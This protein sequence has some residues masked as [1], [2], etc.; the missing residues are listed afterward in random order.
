M[1]RIVFKNIE[2]FYAC[3]EKQMDSS[4]ASNLDDQ[5]VDQV[6]DDAIGR[7]NT[8]R[9]MVKKYLSEHRQEKSAMLPPVLSK[10]LEENCVS[11]ITQLFEDRILEECDLAYYRVS[12]TEHFVWAWTLLIMSWTLRNLK[13]KVEAGSCYN[14]T[15]KLG[16][17]DMLCPQGSKFHLD[18]YN[19]CLQ[20]FENIIEAA[21]LNPPKL[22]D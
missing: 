10:L 17:R 16:D 11:K 9:G 22:V 12:S 3:V 14:Q 4:N 8:R 21:K 19:E 6:Y 7:I 15:H 13:A 5:K 2:E 1:R 20:S 18:F